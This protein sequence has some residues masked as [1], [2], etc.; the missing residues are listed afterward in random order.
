MPAAAVVGDA[1]RVI[2]TVSLDGGQLALLTAQTKVLTPTERPV[3]PDVGSPGVVTLAPPA[4]TVHAPV[5]TLGGLAA[6]V[7]EVAHTV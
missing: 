6:N 1:S 4:I 2:T 7:V 3:T 5:P